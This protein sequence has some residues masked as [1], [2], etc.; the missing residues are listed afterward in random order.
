M[1]KQ[2]TLSVIMPTY[3]SKD[4]VVYSIESILS[5]SFKDFEL[6]IVNDGSTDGTIN[7]LKKYSLDTRIKIINIENSGPANA[8]NIGIENSTGKYIIFIDSDDKFKPNAFKILMSAAKK[9]NPELIIFG[10]NI[11]DKSKRINFQ[12]K[13]KNSEFTSKAE[14]GAS[15]SR[16]YYDNMLNQVWN[17]LYLAEKLKENHI[18]FTNYKYGED[19]LFVFDT[20]M[21]CDKIDVIDDC[22]YDYVMVGSESLTKKFYDRK[23]EVCCIIDNKVRQLSK[24]CGATNKSDN[25]VFDYMFI[26]SVFSCMTNLFDTSCKYNRKQRNKII[27]DIL[28]NKQVI[29]AVT[30]EFNDKLYFKIITLIMRSRIIILNELL[31]YITIKIIQTNYKFFIKLKHNK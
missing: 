5:Q 17:K 9:F 15:L 26:K 16:L 7:T 21:V 1:S 28:N 12:Y 2:P 23:F 24:L 30:K 22:L 14:L 19:R 27:G 29:N 8:R 18:K 10:F 6:I 31:I 3:N 25:Q 13:F 11:I 4:S 20:L